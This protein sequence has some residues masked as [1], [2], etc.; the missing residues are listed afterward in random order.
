MPASEQPHDF[1]RRDTAPARV[2]RVNDDGFAMRHDDVAAEEPLEIRLQLLA[3]A[4]QVSRVVSVTMRTPGDDAELA[5]G[6]LFTEG[7]VT[8]P[9][10]ILHIHQCKSGRRVRVQLRS[11]SG[12][13]LSRLDRGSCQTSS[14]GV[15]GKFSL[16]AVHIRPRTRP[17][18]AW[19]V[20][21]PAIIRQLP[22]TLRAAQNVFERTG[23]L[24]AAALFDAGGHL[25]C[26]R[27][28][29]G[30]HNALDKLIGAQVLAGRTP[31]SE[32][33]LLV[34]GRS[35]FELVQKAAVAGIPILAAVG[36]PSS[37]AVKLAQEHG[38]TLLGFVRR[39]G[40][41]VY[42]GVERVAAGAFAGIERLPV[43]V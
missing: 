20:V 7:I 31:L 43:P 28:D 35:S 30:R 17:R 3:D 1:S 41:N 27:E 8:H 19:P 33:V 36:A 16:Q 38:L 21:D 4:P 18:D 42:A 14:C 5:A 9:N 29:V 39:E 2:Y 10:E 22:M 24:H 26:I 34:S 37:L 40:F 32:S 6:Y 15:C 11:G 23:G 12:V 13:D 25:L